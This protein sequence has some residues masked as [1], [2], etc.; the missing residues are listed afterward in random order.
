MNSYEFADHIGKELHTLGQWELERIAE[1]F[2]SIKVSE[3]RGKLC[4]SED[5]DLD[6]CSNCDE[7]M[8]ESHYETDI[9]DHCDAPKP[10]YIRCEDCSL[11][12]D[13]EE[14]QKLCDEC[15]DKVEHK[16]EAT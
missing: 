3:Y 5:D 9:C 6:V 12:C 15:A 14:D 11:V 1:E 16:L 8:P 2:L 10:G 7:V 4:V 13:G